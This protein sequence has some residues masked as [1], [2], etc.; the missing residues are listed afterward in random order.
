MNNDK[1]IAV[2]KNKGMTSLDALRLVKRKLNVDKIGH[3]GTLDP[4]AE[5][6][7]ILCTGSKTK[8]IDS[9]MNYEKEYIATIFLGEE[10]DTLDLTGKSVFKSK[11]NHQFNK[12]VIKE[13][14]NKYIGDI[15]QIP[16]YYSALKFHGI[17]LYDYARKGIYIRKKPRTVKVREISLLEID[18]GNKVTIYVKCEKGTYIRSLARDIAYDLGT[19]GHLLELKRVA[20]GPFNEDNSLILGNL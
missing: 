18:E 4:F 15:K 1:V 8:E 17:R 2:W 19:Y 9:F 16:P 5:G 7:L 11:K 12:E 13:A 10:T 6:I 14:L 20:I 3:C